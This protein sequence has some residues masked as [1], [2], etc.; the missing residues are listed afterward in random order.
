VLPT[1]TYCYFWG[2]RR[3]GGIF[4]P[5][6]RERKK[7]EPE[8]APGARTPYVVP[9]ISPGART[10]HVVPYKSPGARTPYVVHYNFEY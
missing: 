3:N 9:Y 10:P 1:A 6:A 2:K 5:L 8:A 4:C 7:A